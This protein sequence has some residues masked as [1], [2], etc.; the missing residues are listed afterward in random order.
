MTHINN[1]YH[2]SLGDCLP[3]VIKQTWK[4]VILIAESQMDGHV[5]RVNSSETTEEHSSSHQSEEEE[6]EEE[7]DYAT[8]SIHNEEEF[9]LGYQYDREREMVQSI[10]T[11]FSLACHEE[12]YIVFISTMVQVLQPDN[13]VALAFLGHILDRTSLHAKYTMEAVSDAIIQQLKTPSR[14]HQCMKTLLSKNDRL[15]FSNANSNSNPNAYPLQ[16]VTSQNTSIV[17]T[18]SARWKQSRSSSMKENAPKKKYAATVFK[19]NATI[20][21]SLLAERF[22]G[23]MCLLL[24]NDQVCELLFQWLSDPEEDLKVRLY[25]LLALEKF[26]MTGGIKKIILNHKPSICSIL[27]SV[28]EE[29]EKS[30]C[31][32][33]NQSTHRKTIRH[34]ENL[35]RGSLG[36]LL[37]EETAL[38]NA[39]HPSEKNKKWPLIIKHWLK[40][41][42]GFGLNR[43][44]A[45][46]TPL[47][48]KKKE[49]EEPFG[50]KH[51]DKASHDISHTS[52]VKNMAV[53]SPPYTHKKFSCKR[54]PEKKKEE[55]SMPFGYSATYSFERRFIPP[56][57]AMREVWSKYSQLA[58]CARWSFDNVFA[59]A[60][61]ESER[62]AL[63]LM[64]SWDLSQLSG[65]LNPFDCTPHLKIGGNCLEI[66]NDCTNFESARGTASVRTGKWYYEALLLSGGIIQI[67]W[68]TKNCRFAP[69]EG[70]GVG[71]DCHGFSFDTYRTS[72]W[73]N[74]TAVY[75]PVRRNKPCKTG[76]VVGSFLDLDN[77]LCSFY[78]NGLDIGLTIEFDSPNTS[79]RHKESTSRSSRSRDGGQDGTSSLSSFTSSVSS[80]TSSLITPLPPLPYTEDLPSPTQVTKSLGLFP[81]ISMTTH[82]HALL[83]FGDRPW[84]FP[85][86]L[87]I[88]FKAMKDA[89][90]LDRIF[91][92][93]IKKHIRR[94]QTLLMSRSLYRPPTPEC[95]KTFLDDFFSTSSKSVSNTLSDTDTDSFGTK[96]EGEGDEEEAYLCAI[97]F[98]EPKNILLMPCHHGGLGEECSKVI[99]NCPMC[100]A[101][102]LQRVLVDPAT[103]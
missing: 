6:E 82:Q 68:A 33:Y 94:N 62:K 58:H 18:L 11:L 90:T 25:T 103:N 31:N 60:L 13:P 50:H 96:G 9:S 87:E 84:M 44:N 55:S 64:C 21:W 73:T 5:Q 36:L 53:G 101:F 4:K 69:E 34:S 76:D 56:K 74:G 71:D 32:I 12:G 20:L 95:Q 8:P 67:G 48:C 19:L 77:G 100:R 15:S 28:I 24:W 1:G 49:S 70:H 63:P 80:I 81:A 16:R 83:N 86:P 52:P 78:I 27:M 61:S 102:I 40:S 38:S 65:T 98:D 37:E 99:K 39:I 51:N 54:E 14:I 17:S 29:C 7:E 10:E 57:G 46:E 97:C 72:V 26:A 92:Q 85:P 43:E 45:L 2:C 42:S 30:C 89:G 47:Y 91:H 66:R 41:I 59:S 79:R 75:P 22:A 3:R 93:R 23:E 35:M 88:K